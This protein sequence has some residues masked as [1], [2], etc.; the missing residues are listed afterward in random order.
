M[1]LLIN[2]LFFK[3][4]ANQI[5]EILKQNSKLA[6]SKNLLQ[7][8]ITLLSTFRYKHDSRKSILNIFDELIRSPEF[9]SDTP[10]KIKYIVGDIV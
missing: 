9:N 5:K 10:K 2:S 8:I 4:G 7:N 3:I 1:K 6:Y